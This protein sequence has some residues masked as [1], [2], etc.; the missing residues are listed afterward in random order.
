MVT[1]S[2]LS[3]LNWFQFP[4]WLYAFVD[5]KRTYKTVFTA[6]RLRAQREGDCAEEEPPSSLFVPSGKPFNEIPSSLCGKQVAMRRN[7]PI[8]VVHITKNCPWSMS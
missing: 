2:A 6:S 7:V 5:M 1:A 4:Y 8:A 3:R